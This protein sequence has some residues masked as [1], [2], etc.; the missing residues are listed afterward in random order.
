LPVNSINVP[1]VVE[2]A[3]TR[4]SDR[5]GVAFDYLLQTAM[6]ESALDPGARAKTSSATGL[7]QFIDSTWLEV[8]KEEGPRLGY[9][10][11]ANKISS[12]PNGNY[13]VAD[14]VDRTQILALRKDPDMAADMGAA[15][16][17]RNG[18]Y[19]EQRFGRPP[20]PGE[21][22]IAHFLGAN[23]AG[24]FFDAGLT[25]PDAAAADLFPA[26]AGANKSI[27][28]ENG[29]PASIREVYQKLVA[30]HR[31]LAAQMPPEP[32]PAVSASANSLFANAA[33]VNAPAAFAAQQLAEQINPGSLPPPD[34]SAA[35]S[36]ATDT[37][38]K[39]AVPAGASATG[40]TLAETP[41]PDA[42]PATPPPTAEATQD[43]PVPL[44]PAILSPRVNAPPAGRPTDADFERFFLRG[45]SQK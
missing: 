6:R 35:V 16:T 10:D 38:P 42:L 45:L 15:F 7:F 4:A 24:R 43:R 39:S 17:L 23:G 12:D 27:F 41:P 21:L 11:L 28:Y 13:W 20:S 2:R 9:E 34:F 29:Q 8:L 30:K 1:P 5:N 3:L 44:G 33:P 32:A 19:L 37:G 31:E 18:Q 14:P 26:A 22:Y 40:P 25:Q 36:F